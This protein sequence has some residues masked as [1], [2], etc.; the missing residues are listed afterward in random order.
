M[1]FY[2]EHFFLCQNTQIAIDTLE[3][4][5]LV[6]YSFVLLDIIT[7]ALSILFYLMVHVCQVTLVVSDSVVPHGLQPTRLLCP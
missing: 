6:I 4:L 5:Y 2:E 1:N 7:Y 3:R